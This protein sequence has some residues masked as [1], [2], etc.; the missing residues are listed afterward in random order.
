MICPGITSSKHIHRRFLTTGAILLQKNIVWPGR[1]PCVSRKAVDLVFGPY[2]ICHH[3]ILCTWR[4]GLEEG[5]V[6]VPSNRL[7]KTVLL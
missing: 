6:P 5:D 2:S 7:G 1:A 3:E 4:E